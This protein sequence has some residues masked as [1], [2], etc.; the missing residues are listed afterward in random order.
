MDHRNAVSNEMRKAK[1]QYYQ[2]LL[3]DADHS[4]AFKAVDN[5]LNVDSSNLPDTDSMYNLCYQFLD[6][7]TNKIMKIR[8]AIDFSETNMRNSETLAQRVVEHPMTDLAAT[9]EGEVQR[10]IQTA[11]PKSS[12]LDPLPTSPLKSTTDS[13]DQRFF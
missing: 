13:P 6:F 1:I 2:Y 7:F 3:Q 5:L 11:K 10:I 4:A 12:S 8:A 9:S